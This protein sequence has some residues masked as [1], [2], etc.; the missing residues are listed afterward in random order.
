M[1]SG[2]GLARLAACAALTAGAAGAVGAQPPLSDDVPPPPRIG[3]SPEPIP[4]PARPGESRLASLPEEVEEIVVIGEESQWRLPDLGSSF[5]QRQ[6]EERRQGRIAAEFLP[7][8]DPEQPPLTSG[9]LR[10]DR[11]AERVGFIQ[12]FRIRFGRRNR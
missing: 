1:T 12:L 11:E 2:S 6:E 7:L 8:Y 3:D 9:L 10:I 4:P 5:R